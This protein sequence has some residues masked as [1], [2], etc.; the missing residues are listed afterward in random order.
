MLIMKKLFFTLAN[1]SAEKSSKG[2]IFTSDEL[3]W[4]YGVN[5]TSSPVP[6]PGG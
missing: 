6:P 5:Y 1:Y 2:S 3:V 4:A